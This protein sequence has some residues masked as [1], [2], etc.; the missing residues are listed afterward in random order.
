VPVIVNELLW[1]PLDQQ[2]GSAPDA[3][4][5]LQKDGM[6]PTTI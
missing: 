2:T 5:G 3:N 6:V 1:A 4:S